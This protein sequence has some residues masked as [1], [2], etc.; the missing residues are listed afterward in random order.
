[1]PGVTSVDSSFEPSPYRLPA[2]FRAPHRSP[3][4]SRHRKRPAEKAATAAFSSFWM[5]GHEGCGRLSAADVAQTRDE[6][7]GALDFGIRTLRENAAWGAIDRQGRLD[8]ASIRPRCVA[9]R[10]LGIQIVWTL[11]SK[12]WP[13]DLKFMSA[14]FVDRFARYAGSAAVQ[15][16]DLN[17]LAVPVYT[18]INELSFQAWSLFSSGLIRRQDGLRPTAGEIKQQLALACIAACDAILSRVPIAR[19]LHTDPLEHVVAPVDR[20]AL[21]RGAARRSEQQFEGWDLISGRARG[22]LGGKSRYLDL[23][24][25]NY[26]AENQWELGSGKRL[27]WQID[28]LRRLP[29]SALLRSVHARYHRPVVIAET[30]H[31]GVRRGP[32]IREVAAEVRQAM[33]TGVDV[34]GICLYPLIDERDT[35]DSGKWLRRGLWEVQSGAR[36]NRHLELDAPYASALRAAQSITGNRRHEG[37]NVLAACTSEPV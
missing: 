17:P 21:A 25:V 1:M 35:K 2:G 23:V 10:E 19:L 11:F 33:R 7:R 3:G 6:Y 32:W 13:S 12:P 36:E 24:G 8:F 37:R 28:D 26:Y 34:E 20:F 16:A 9:A 22:E 30:S 4:I 29:L 27:A 5:G 31:T 18:P 15:L 14:A